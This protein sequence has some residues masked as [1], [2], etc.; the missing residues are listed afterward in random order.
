MSCFGF[1]EAPLITNTAEYALR[2]TVYLAAQDDRPATT[3]DIFSATRI[4][5][6]YLSKV[7]QSLSRAGIISSKRGLHGGSVLARP[8]G[9]LTVYDVVQAVSPLQRIRSCPLDFKTHGARLCPLHRRLD[10]AMETVERAFRDSTLAD[11]L[12]QPNHSKPLCELDEQLKPSRV[13]KRNSRAV[14][15]TV[16]RRRRT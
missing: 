15:I 13:N 4:P 7:L 11:L 9:E 16:S 5:I 3:K 2:V 10:Q 1:T 12:A 6:G 8:P 14:T